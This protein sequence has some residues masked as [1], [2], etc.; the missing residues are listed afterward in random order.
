MV[1]ILGVMILVAYFVMER[2]DLNN[3]AMR[4]ADGWEG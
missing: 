2:I 4:E 1:G 3:R